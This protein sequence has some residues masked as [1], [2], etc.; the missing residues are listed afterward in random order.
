[1]IRSHTTA[2]HTATVQVPTVWVYRDTRVTHIK[3]LILACVF[4][5]GVLPALKEED[6]ETGRMS[7][8]GRALS[9]LSGQPG[10]SQQ[11]QQQAAGPAAGSA[12]AMTLVQAAA[13]ETS[14]V[15]LMTD[16]GQVWQAL[17]YHHQGL[18]Q[19]CWRMSNSR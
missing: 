12:P 2:T 8:P 18:L 15:P 10:A 17:Q 4:A 11:A 5:G 7:T 19:V 16:P 14:S 9:L 6:E 13:P 1:M 3:L